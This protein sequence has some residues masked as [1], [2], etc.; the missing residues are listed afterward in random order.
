MPRPH[1]TEERPAW[2]HPRR[3]RRG[4]DRL[5][6]VEHHAGRAT[7]LDDDMVDA[8]IRAYLDAGGTRR[9]R[10]RLREGPGPSARKAPGGP[11][12]LDRLS[13]EAGGQVGGQN[14][15]RGQSGS[16]SKIAPPT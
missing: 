14:Q 1:E 10:E 12:A 11:Q 15:R 16:Y 13:F 6:V 7:L 3:D 2:V 9:A 4:P 8:G 5:A